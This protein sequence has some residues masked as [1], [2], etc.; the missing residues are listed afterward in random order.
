MLVI[1]KGIVAGMVQRRT[2]IGEGFS[3]QI[4]FLAYMS[5]CL[6]DKNTRLFTME[7]YFMPA[8]CSVN[9]ET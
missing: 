3:I 1:N 6:C 7:G 5:V 4:M 9:V 8:G 2:T